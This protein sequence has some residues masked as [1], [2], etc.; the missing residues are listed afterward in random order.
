MTLVINNNWGNRM[1]LKGFSNK[2]RISLFCSLV[3]LGLTVSCRTDQTAF[4]TLERTEEFSGQTS[5]SKVDLIL[6]LDKSPSMAG[7]WSKLGDRFKRFAEVYLNPNSNQSLGDVRILSLRQDAFWGNE[8]YKDNQ[9]KGID[10][11]QIVLDTIDPNTGQRKPVSTIISEFNQYIERESKFL[12]GHFLTRFDQSI[13]QGLERMMRDRVQYIR[14]NSFRVIISTN[15]ADDLGSA[16]FRP[17]GGVKDTISPM[18]LNFKYFC[19]ESL[20]GRYTDRTGTFIATYK[21]FSAV[22]LMQN[23]I[24]KL[25]PN[26]NKVIAEYD[27]Q[28]AEEAKESITRRFLEIDG[29]TENSTDADPRVAFVSLAPYK[30]NS[31]AK[32][33]KL[34]W[35]DPKNNYLWNSHGAMNLNEINLHSTPPKKIGR[36]IDLFK[37]ELKLFSKFSS[38]HDICDAN[39]TEI[40]DGLGQELQRYGGQLKLKHWMNLQNKITIKFANQNRIVFKTFIYGQ[41]PKITINKTKA[42]TISINATLLREYNPISILVTYTPDLSSGGGP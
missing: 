10:R 40:L 7:I 15:D 12:N 3:V 5:L 8:V 4:T 2:S 26:G 1:F 36:I 35:C 33:R 25:T 27:I 9:K 37:S 32:I 41:N 11:F 28:S 16:K 19:P 39:L 18:T 29:K 30:P 23:R 20:P 14:K 31:L 13:E 21:F 34:G 38:K 24:T 6:F 17:D 22:C 42:N